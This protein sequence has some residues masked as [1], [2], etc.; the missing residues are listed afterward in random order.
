MT[1]SQ[2]LHDDLRFVRRAVARRGMLEPTPRA[3]PVL[4]GLFI[5][6]AFTLLDFNLRAAMWTFAVAAPLL[7]VASGLIGAVQGRRQGQVDQRAGRL[8]A[9]HWGTIFL[10]MLPLAVLAARH[11]VS[12]EGV[13][14]VATLLVGVVYFLGGVHFDRRWMP[15][16]LLLIIGSAAITFVPRYPWTILGGV[17]CLALILPSLLP[18]RSHE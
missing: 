11:R 15:S 6:V 8:H 2:Q 14:Q 4:W 13:G 7:G 10:A 1:E 5:L 3:I 16:G 12:G 9:L 18:N 17:V